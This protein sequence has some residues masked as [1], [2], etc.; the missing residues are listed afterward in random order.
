MVAMVIMVVMVIMVAMVIVVAMGRD[1]TGQNCHL[2]LAFQVTCDWQAV[3]F[4]ILAMF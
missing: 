3:A 2:N 4:A 1:G